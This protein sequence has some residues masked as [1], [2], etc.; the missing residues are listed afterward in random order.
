MGNNC[1]S[2][3][4]PVLR[5]KLSDDIGDVTT[6]F[7]DNTCQSTDGVYKSSC[8]FMTATSSMP[9]SV[10]TNPSYNSRSFWGFCAGLTD[11]SVRKEYCSDLGSGEWEYR[12]ASN[13]CYFS[14]CNPGQYQPTGCCG[15]C[16]GI[17]GKGV[18]CSRRNFNGDP[19][20]C[21]LNDY[22]GC[23]VTSG[24]N[25]PCKFNLGFSM[26]TQGRNIDSEYVNPGQQC[27]PGDTISSP[28]WSGWS[29]LDT[30]CP[31][32]C[33]PCFRGVTYDGNTVLTSDGTSVRKCSQSKI[34]TKYYTPDKYGYTGC[35][36]TLLAYATGEDLPRDSIEWTYRWMD[37]TGAPLRYGC[38]NVLV[39][40]IF[41]TSNGTAPGY[42]KGTGIPSQS[43]NAVGCSVV[44]AYFNSITGG[45]GNCTIFPI[46][47]YFTSADGIAYARVMLNN[48]GKRYTLAGYRIGSMVGESTYNIFQD[49][50]YTNIIC[51]LPFIAQDL[52]NTTC[53]IYT[54]TQL[55]HN[56][57]VA[58]W[59]GCYMQNGEYQKY[60]NEYQ[61]N[62]QCTP[63][64]NKVG[65]IPIVNQANIVQTCNQSI[66]I[67]D[68]VAINLANTNVSGNINVNQMCSNCSSGVGASCSCRISSSV[69]NFK[70]QV[71]NVNT[72]EVCTSTL[73][74]VVNPDTGQT[75]TMDCSDVRQ[76]QEIFRQQQ[77]EEERLRQA[78]IRERNR[79]LLI[80]VFILVL[81]I[82]IAAYIIRPTFT[83]PKEKK[84][85]R[86]LDIPMGDFGSKTGVS[87]LEG[88]NTSSFMNT[89]V[90]DVSSSFGTDV[91]IKEL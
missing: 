11:K 58:N 35:R 36:K 68:D 76:S 17:S 24:P 30:N 32:T 19:I 60:V 70:G 14:D 57:S 46:S 12:S 18:T 3:R 43:P 72:G 23:G 48:V 22:S 90:D 25:D 52:L 59:C 81:A 37:A 6:T 31:K 40:N 84:I 73:C 71:N 13:S 54:T 74:T 82:V 78:A 10:A 8:A 49:F 15:W 26:D 29:C 89:L 47:D 28:S 66:C 7:N 65:V 9:F 33:N 1:S 83:D 53:S 39:R 55:E 21:C 64:C 42:S 51:K 16:C 20:Q 50:L 88:H 56:P 69:L 45:N 4:N 27:T 85:D 77:L 41:D 91:G 63:M 44:D 79:N 87:D 34:N 75:V 86:K 80:I 67:I 61:V 5:N 2:I 62:K 38:L